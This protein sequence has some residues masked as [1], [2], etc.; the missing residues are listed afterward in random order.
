MKFE[1]SLPVLQLLPHSLTVAKNALNSFISVKNALLYK[2]L[3][4]LY[5]QAHMQRQR[6]TAESK[7]E[8]IPK[9]GAGSEYG[10]EQRIEARRKK[11]G[12]RKKEVK[13]EDLPWLLKTGGRGGKT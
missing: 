13:D 11:R 12:Y 10:R 8:E 6:N 4:S 3:F 5:F 2:L 1:I 9:F 7:D